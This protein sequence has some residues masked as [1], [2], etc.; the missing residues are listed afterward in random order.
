MFAFIFCNIEQSVFLRATL[1]AAPEF[2]VRFRGEVGG[3][4]MRC[5]VFVVSGRAPE[6]KR[7]AKSNYLNLASV[8][9]ECLH[10]PLV[11]YVGM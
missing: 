1:N 7:P 3:R 11:V 2:F 6:W 5:D 4:V 9:N 10:V 8:L